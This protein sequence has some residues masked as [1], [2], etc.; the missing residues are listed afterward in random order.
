MRGLL[1]H[2]GS[3]QT[4]STYRRARVGLCTAYRRPRNARFRTREARRR[5]LCVDRDR[6]SGGESIREPLTAVLDAADKTD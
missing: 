1:C 2:S 5:E 6:E 4:A 3:V